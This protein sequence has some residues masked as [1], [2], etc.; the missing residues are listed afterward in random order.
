MNSTFQCWFVFSRI[1]M[2]HWASLSD[3][4]AFYWRWR[5]LCKTEALGLFDA[6]SVCL[7]CYSARKRVCESLWKKRVC[8]RGRYSFCVRLFK[9]KPCHSE[10]HACVYVRERLGE[11]E[12]DKFGNAACVLVSTNRQG[13]WVHVNKCV[14]LGYICWGESEWRHSSSNTLQLLEKVSK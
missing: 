7:L 14:S 1:W 2:S 9:D 8:L 6:A 13:V 10:R 3:K 11:E 5:D 4:Q 12:P